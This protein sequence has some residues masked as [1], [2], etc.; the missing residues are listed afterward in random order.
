MAGFVSMSAPCNQYLLNGVASIFCR[1]RAKYTLELLPVLIEK[2]GSFPDHHP[3]SLGRL[4]ELSFPNVSSGK[5][6]E[7]TLRN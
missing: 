7:V 5:C 3:S 1:P 2:H 6:F 4:D